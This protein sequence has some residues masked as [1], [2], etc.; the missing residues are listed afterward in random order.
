[1]LI[2]NL[3]SSFNNWL[4]SF[5]LAFIIIGGLLLNAWLG[6]PFPATLTSRLGMVGGVL[7]YSDAEVYLTGAHRFIEFGYLD[8]WNMRR[9]LNTLMLSY[10]LKITAFNYWYVLLIQA[11]ACIYALT[12]YLKTI[13][14]DLGIASTLIALLFVGYY[15]Q[16]YINS[17]LSETLGLTLGLFSFVLLWNG[18]IQKKPLIYNSGMAM[19]AVALCARAGP[20]L[21]AG[22]FLL[23]VLMR[24]F[25]NSRY[26][27]A[28]YAFLSFA[29]PFYL[30]SKLSTLYGNPTNEG[31]AY[32]NFG[33]VLYGLVNGGKSWTFAYEDDHMKQLL[34]NKSEAQQAL[35]LYAESW[36]AF[37][38]NP[39][40]LFIGMGKY[41]SAFFVWFIRALTFGKGM[42]LQ[43]TS[44][45]SVL[46]LI[47]TG[48]KVYRKRIW[49][50]RSYLFLTIVF[51]SIAASS[52]FIF[53]D[54]GIRVF[55]VAIPYLAALFG[56]GFAKTTAM[57][58]HHTPQNALSICAGL[59]LLFGALLSPILPNSIS[60][61][62]IRLR[63]I[64]GQETLLTYN[65]KNQ[66]HVFINS[67]HGLH[68]RHISSQILK[69]SWYTDAFSDELLG[70]EMAKIANSYTNI[71]LVLLN[72]YD[73]IS[74]SS[75]WVLITSHTL[76][77]DAPWIEIQASLIADD[78]KKIYKANSCME[79]KL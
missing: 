55:A 77:T 7:P 70:K 12:L 48:V 41:L 47:F 57:E 23:L 49:Q 19:L 69:D 75:K 54:G 78:F 68:F 34:L 37:I 2:K 29:I 65:L 20:N 33:P 30:I 79:H 50:Y 32:S 46:F 51:A 21:M 28:L 74:H 11:A 35:T 10:Y 26:K 13:W 59:Y 67:K 36:Q 61:Q 6:F 45:I 5:L 53:R 64:P 17:P 27:D 40:N 31:M 4:F 8:A 39:L 3:N 42:V 76:D 24:P 38:K 1:M 66:P 73:Y 9:P 16:T 52:M 58:E 56:F 14:D 72:I 60:P 25:T 63:H 62:D 71:D 44:I 22:A 43:I 18:W 15:A